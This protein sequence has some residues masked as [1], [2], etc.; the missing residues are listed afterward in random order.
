VVAAASL[1]STPAWMSAVQ[2]TPEGFVEEAE[3]VA[4]VVDA[5]VVPVLAALLTVMSQA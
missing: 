3:L 1:A 2:S 5:A 4:D